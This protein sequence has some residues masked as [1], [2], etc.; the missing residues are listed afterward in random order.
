M[1][2]TYAI[3]H[4]AIRSIS[5]EIA[6]GIKERQP[7]IVRCDGQHQ[8][9]FFPDSP[10][11]LKINTLSIVADSNPY[12]SFCESSLYYIGSP[13]TIHRQ[14]EI[15]IRL[16]YLEGE[17]KNKVSAY[18]SKEGLGTV[19]VSRDLVYTFYKYIK[20]YAFGFAICNDKANEFHANNII[21]KMFRQDFPAAFAIALKNTGNISHTNQ[22]V[23]ADAYQQCEAYTHLYEL[24]P[25]LGYMW[26]P[27][28]RDGIENTL[29]EKV[30]YKSYAEQVHRYFNLF[31]LKPLGIKNLYALASA[32]PYF[33]KT[34]LSSLFTCLIPEDKMLDTYCTI[35]NGT[36]RVVPMLNGMQKTAFTN[37]LT[38]LL[39]N[40]TGIT[41][42]NKTVWRAVENMFTGRVAGVIVHSELNIPEARAYIEVVQLLAERMD[43]RS[44][45]IHSDWLIR[46][47]ASS[48]GK[49]WRTVRDFK[50]RYPHRWKSKITQWA[51]ARSNRWHTDRER[52]A[53]LIEEAEIEEMKLI[54]WSGLNA[55]TTI[56]S[57]GDTY[58]FHELTSAYD[59]FMEGKALS[60]CVSS[61]TSKCKAGLSHIFSVKKNGECNTTLELQ[62]RG[63]KWLA[64]QN[65]GFKNATP[66]KENTDTVQKFIKLLNKM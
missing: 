47:A 8:Y 36:G 18:A 51:V 26:T 32:K 66:T 40:M 45:H 20:C 54:R 7:R 55:D 24:N 49:L 42:Y 9:T 5:R 1:P 17:I 3:P 38:L 41:K 29:G 34:V 57:S 43:K 50:H 58:G 27:Y 48:D 60:H 4:S 37:N 13:E 14:P 15:A 12:W 44:Y 35:S 16:G 33:F 11:A 59:L 10:D 61:Y 65:H 56:I 2:N 62:K 64:N 46:H 52:E 22:T 19:D 21:R 63:V 31:G 53:L 23:I 39:N 30:E 28:F 25:L 6:N